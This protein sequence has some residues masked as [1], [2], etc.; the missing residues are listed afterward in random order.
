MIKAERT[1]DFVLRIINHV[2]SGHSRENDIYKYMDDILKPAVNELYG[3]T[4]ECKAHMDGIGEIKMTYFD[5]GNINSTHLFGL[6]ELI[7]FC[8]Y[9]QNTLTYNKVADLGANIGLHSIVLAKLGFEVSAYE[10]DIVHLER[11]RLNL[12][13]NN[14]RDRVKVYPCAVSTTKETK[15]F[16]RVKGNTTSSH[17]KGA[18]D[19]AYG[20]LESLKVETVEFESILRG[21]DLLKIDVEGHESEIICS[22]K[23]KDW[24]NCDAILEVGSEKN[25]YEIYEKFK[26]SKINM[27]SQMTNWRKVET[28]D[29]MPKSYKDGSVFI[30]IKEKMKWK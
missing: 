7:I 17:L 28:M 5:M 13:E 29:Q 15:E 30:T 16:V 12:N 23:L 1:L 20:N 9:K 25:S 4:T 3:K 10:P 2:T 6:D 18:K 14:V 24:E 22:S 26:N 8:L 19:T 21:N 27:F 11:L